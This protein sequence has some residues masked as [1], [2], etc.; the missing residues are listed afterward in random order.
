[1]KK[2]T[3]NVVIRYNISQDDRKGIYFYGF[4]KSKQA[5]NVHIYNNTHYV[6]KGLHVEVFA[7]GRTP[8]NSTFENNIFYFEGQGEWG[9]NAAGINT[10]FRNNV[11]HNI[12]PHPSETQAIV[13]DPEFER[14]GEAGS[15][16]DLTTMNGLRGYQL[17]SGS[18][19]VDAGVVIEN[20][21]GMDFVRTPIDAGGADIGAFEF[22]KTASSIEKSQ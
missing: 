17:K 2:P 19:C 8:I 21:G 1:M 3:R 22:Q 11:Y 6:R 9:P 5:E 18:P 13:A 10:V 7:E 14:P 4:D 12:Q 15:V 20:A 16:I